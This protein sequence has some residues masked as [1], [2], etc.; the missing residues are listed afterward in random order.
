MPDVIS[1]SAVEM[2]E[3]YAHGTASREELLAAYELVRHVQSDTD[4]ESSAKN[5]A[6]E[7]A[8]EDAEVAVWCVLEHAMHCV[9]RSAANAASEGYS[10]TWQRVWEEAGQAE[11]DAQA[12]L[13]HDIFGNPFHPFSLDTTWPSWHDGLLAS[14]ARQIYDSRDFSDLSVMADALEEAGCANPDIVSHCRE[15]GAV[16]V[17][18]CWVV[19][20]CLGKS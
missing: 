9:Q 8:A 11:A 3:R 13:L 18:G 17:R 14:M 2:A 6:R 12:V 19:D 5:A 4:A 7:V 10:D 20:L 15:Q 16:H 1:R